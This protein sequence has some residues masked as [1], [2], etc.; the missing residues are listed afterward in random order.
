MKL[1]DI[2]KAAGS[3]AVKALVPGGGVIVDLVNGFLDDKNK[4]P[5]DA[6]GSQI[7]EKIDALPPDEQR[8]LW[9]KELD[10]EIAEIQEWT[11]TMSVLAQTDQTG[12]STRPQ[13]AKMMAQVVAFSVIFFSASLSISIL[14]NNAEMVKQLDSTWVI[15]LAILGTPTALLRAYF[16]MR[17]KEKQSKYQIA[18]AP[19]SSGLIENILSM[20]KK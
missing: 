16:G 14:T 19:K 1:G 4:L 8:K 5:T 17:S 20:F 2:L 12:A 10:V 11:K 3:V 18:G 7:K 13:I 9:E 6:T 15:A